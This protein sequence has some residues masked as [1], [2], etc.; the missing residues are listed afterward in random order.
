MNITENV[1]DIVIIGAG[2]A[3]LSA[4]I[5]GVRAGK[6]VLVLEEKAY[7][8]QII[9]TP[10]VENYPGIAK[11][12]GFEFATNLYNQ[13]KGLGATVKF[14]RVVEIKS[15]EAATIGIKA[16]DDGTL[17]EL[18]TVTGK[19]NVVITDSGE[20]ICKS[21]II[22]TGAKNRPLGVDREKE[23]IGVGISY[24]AT[25][26]GMFFRGKDVAVVGGGNTALEDAHFLSNYCNKVYVIHRRDQ[27]RGESRLVDRIKSKSNV[28]LVLSSKVVELL[29]ADSIEGIVVENTIDGKSSQI[30]CQGVFVAIGQMPDNERFKNVVSLDQY[31]YIVAGEDCK[32]SCEGIYAAGDCRTKTVR[33]L[34]TAA[35][36]GAVAA[37]AACE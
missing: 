8:G 24:C 11:I 21:V 30:A 19:V 13:A 28:E 31:G 17:T 2:T 29:G 9:N 22:A 12:S 4:A 32:T 7:G 16:V 34:T 6:R 37:I 25:C 3:G 33:Q 35:A 10:E 14:E 27:F 36:D 15:Q 26:D 5:Y 1:Y 23:L 18:T 20:Y